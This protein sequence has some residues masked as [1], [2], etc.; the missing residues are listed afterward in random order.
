MMTIKMDK[1]I[2]NNKYRIHNRELNTDKYVD[3]MLD[4]QHKF[5][6]KTKPTWTKR[7]KA[8][9]EQ[10]PIAWLMNKK[11]PRNLINTS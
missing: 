6:F 8:I 1:C 9:L 7:L 4:F 3:I 10:S 11:K 5:S 2:R